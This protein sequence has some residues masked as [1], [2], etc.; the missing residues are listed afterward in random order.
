M[1]SIKYIGASKR[2]RSD[3]KGAAC[4]RREQP[5]WYGA[6]AR[7]THRR[8]R[9]CPCACR[10]KGTFLCFGAVASVA[11]GTR[12][13]HAAEA[14]PLALTRHVALQQQ[15][16]VEGAAAVALRRRKRALAPEAHLLCAGCGAAV[17][18]QQPHQQRPVAPRGG[19][20]RR[21]SVGHGAR[22]RRRFG[23]RSVGALLAKPAAAAPTAQH[24]H[25]SEG[26]RRSARGGPQV[27]PGGSLLA[28][29]LRPSQSQ[30]R[31]SK[32]SFH[33]L[34]RTAHITGAAYMSADT[35]LQEHAF[36]RLRCHC[37]SDQGS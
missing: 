6:S 20:R 34:Q 5:C 8:L 25:G 14:A 22:R 36:P 26:R 19:R 29:A 1:M 17:A 10:G 13:E 2:R 11:R 23:A 32:S 27:W 30:R 37:R 28:C 18:G 3:R 12:L 4:A 35:P 16:A 21:R 7:A 24:V 15:P 33:G 9:R 31:S